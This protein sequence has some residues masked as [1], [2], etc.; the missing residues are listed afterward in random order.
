MGQRCCCCCETQPDDGAA[1]VSSGSG[2]SGSGSKGPQI[3]GLGGVLRAKESSY[4][5][6]ATLTSLV[7]AR[8]ASAGDAGSDGSFHS[9]CESTEDLM[10]QIAGS[11]ESAAAFARPGRPRKPPVS[12]NR[13]N[14]Y[15]W[16][17]E[18][19]RMVVDG[20]ARGTCKAKGK[21]SSP[22]SVVV[23]ATT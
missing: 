18:L 10:R 4:V 9:A 20:T 21:P 23:G 15:V 16:L 14:Q 13:V 3:L 1:P 17:E 19:L 7:V 11:R 5:E 22:L 12:S 6:L 2:S 8:C